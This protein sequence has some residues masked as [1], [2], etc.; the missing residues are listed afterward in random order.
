MY[1]A[2]HKKQAYKSGITFYTISFFYGVSFGR[3]EQVLRT[4]PGIY[5]SRQVGCL[6]KR[7]QD[8]DNFSGFTW[9]GEIGGYCV[10]SGT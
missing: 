5:D 4:R 9:N 10:W 1:H 7:N 2:S 3:L 8:K 6:A